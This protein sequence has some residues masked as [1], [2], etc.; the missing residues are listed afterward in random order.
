MDT[1]IEGVY[2]WHTADEGHR[3]VVVYNPGRTKVSVLDVGTLQ[4]RRVEKREM[5]YMREPVG[6]CS[7]MSLA[8]LLKRKAVAHRRLGLGVRAETVRLITDRLRSTAR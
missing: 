3:L 4:V 1:V 2:D 6:G 5:R 8:R 7:E